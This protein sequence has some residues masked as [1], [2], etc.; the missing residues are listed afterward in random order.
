MMHFEITYKDWHLMKTFV[1]GLFKDAKCIFCYFLVLFSFVLFTFSIS[2]SSSNLSLFLSHFVIFPSLALL[3]SPCLP[4][5]PSLCT[6]NCSFPM[7]ILSSSLL[8]KSPKPLLTI[9]VLIL[10]FNLYLIFSNCKILWSV[11][12]G[13]ERSWFS[14]RERNIWYSSISLIHE[15]FRYFS[16]QLIFL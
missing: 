13:Q 16:C 1:I 8:S 4:S 9:L 12:W 2:L 6:Y 11:L 15:I 5:Y 3:L 7:S 14:P 10:H